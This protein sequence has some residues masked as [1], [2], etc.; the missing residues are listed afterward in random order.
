M[1]EKALRLTQRDR[2]CGALVLVTVLIEKCL[3]FLDWKVCL[4]QKHVVVSGPSSSL[5]GHVR[6][7]VDVVLPWMS[8]VVLNQ[9]TRYR[10]SVLIPS[11]PLRREE[12]NV[13]TL[14]SNN[15]CHLRLF[16]KSANITN[17]QVNY[18]YIPGS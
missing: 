10:V 11:H 5:D 15:N 4:I 14:L 7:E 13:M 6:T 8:H 2:S 17:S 16:I 12:A 1:T 3:E 9:C 18:R